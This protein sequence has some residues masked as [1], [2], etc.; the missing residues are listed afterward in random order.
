MN[1]ITGTFF[2]CENGMEMI[3][4]FKLFI[5]VHIDMHQGSWLIVINKEVF[6]NV[7]TS[8]WFLKMYFT[9]FKMY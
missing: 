7:C 6:G 1:A 5:L 2:N 4:I 3:Y 8:F 9:S